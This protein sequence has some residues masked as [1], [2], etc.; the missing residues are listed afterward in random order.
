M[1]DLPSKIKELSPGFNNTAVA[2]TLIIAAGTLA[3]YKTYTDAKY[4]RETI[5]SY[6]KKNGFIFVSQPVTANNMSVCPT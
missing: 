3:I 6:D 1:N 2:I 4:N 5:C